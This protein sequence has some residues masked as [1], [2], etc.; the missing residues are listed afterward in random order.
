MKPTFRLAWKHLLPSALLLVL[1]SA[2][3]AERAANPPAAAV[4]SLEALFASAW[5]REMR[6]DPLYASY[7]GDRRFDREWPDAS[8]AAYQRR[9]AGDEA[10]LQQ[11]KRIDRAVLPADEQLSYDLFERQYAARLAAWPFKPWLYELRASEGV[12]TLSTV[13][14]VL[15]FATSADYEAWIARLSSIDT[16]LDQYTTQLETAVR[17]RRTQPKVI[18]ER[19]LP[20]LTAQITDKA[21]DSPFYEPFTRM[22]PGIPSADRL[23]LQTAGREAVA[24]TVIPAYRRFEKFFR[25]RY[26]PACRDSIGIWD[27]PD[28][29]AFYRQ[30]VSFHTTTALSPE[31]IHEIG[32]AEVARIRGEMQKIMTQT[33]FEGSFEQF[34]A[35]L[36]T[37][38]R[39]Y[40]ETPDELFRAYVVAA[41]LI[42]PELVHL[43]GVLPRT[44]YG[45]RAIPATIAAN[46]TTAYYQP[47]SADGRR[48]GYYY[49]NLYRPEV[50]PKYEIE[51]LTVH[52]A[53]PG[54]HLQ[55]AIAQEAGELPAFRRNSYITAFG[56][57]WALYTEGL[58]AELGL[59]KDPYS[60]FGQL[61]YDMWRAVR[62]VV[63]TGM[64]HKKWTRQ[65]A[66]DYFK[67]NAAKTDADIV[68]EI[69]RY[70]GWPGQ[71][72]AYKIGQLRIAE[73][74]REAEAKL[75]ARFD[76]RRFHDAVLARGDVP[77]ETLTRLLRE[78]MAAEAARPAG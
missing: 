33:G 59:Y 26:L 5:E 43:F 78:W 75:G 6:E 34:F 42:E 71:A 70:I 65:Q 38:P 44:P 61:T 19:V 72:L 51:V 47:P 3:G 27:T 58:G 64:H 60:K 63:D 4:Q 67:A 62:L 32:L 18:M 73:L 77:L 1:A 29:E 14:E 22:P 48:P 11:L 53:V 25:E 28:G 55:T 36:R 12:H 23:R 69:D 17:E 41:K 9:H 76:I 24:R 31:R 46:T 30:R 57:G 35:F 40:Y 13:A 20:V 49:V 15:P 10:T 7:V 68:N 56:E 37:D 66:I 21:E 50:R 2:Q 8:A 45:V 54:H 74:R 52:E 16:Y 39:F